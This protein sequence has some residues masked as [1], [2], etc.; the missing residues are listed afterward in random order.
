MKKLKA[1]FGGGEPIRQVGQIFYRALPDVVKTALTEMLQQG[2]GKFGEHMYDASSMEVR[3]PTDEER[4][5]KVQALISEEDRMRH[6]M[7]NGDGDGMMANKRP[8]EMKRQMV[9]LFLEKTREGKGKT[10][11]VK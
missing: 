6:K 3:E 4:G 8:E 11:L 5:K 9:P 7:E 2:D 1:E 10:L